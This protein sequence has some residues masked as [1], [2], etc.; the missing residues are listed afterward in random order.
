MS[1]IDIIKNRRSIYD[2]NDQLPVS[3]KVVVNTIKH[4]TVESPT[5]FN[6]QSSHLVIL[7]NE[8]HKKLWEIVT[9]TLKNK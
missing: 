6:M 5:A 8:D 7:M 4:V 2:L 9:N 3:E 1:Y